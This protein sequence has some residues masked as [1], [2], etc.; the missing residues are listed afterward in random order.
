MEYLNQNRFVLFNVLFAWFFFFPTSQVQCSVRRSVIHTIPLEL[1]H[2]PAYLPI[3]CSRCY[4]AQQPPWI[5]R[6]VSN[7]VRESRL[8]TAVVFNVLLLVYF[9]KGN[10]ES[11]LFFPSGQKGN[12]FEQA[13]SNL[14]VAMLKSKMVSEVVP[15]Y[16][17]QCCVSDNIK[18]ILKKS[19]AK[20]VCWP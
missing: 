8:H 4:M 5:A 20:L 6:A 11:Y 10:I 2:D 18:D 16:F 19:K 3:I 12:L 15:D 1:I 14:E 9:E 7:S 17:C 13:Y